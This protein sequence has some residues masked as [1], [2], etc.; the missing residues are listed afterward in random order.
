VQA[1]LPEPAITRRTPRG[2]LFG[3]HR[4]PPS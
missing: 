4:H 3:R 1:L 2:V